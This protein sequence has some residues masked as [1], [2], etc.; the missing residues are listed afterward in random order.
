[1]NLRNKQIINQ[2][3]SLANPWLK[4]PQERIDCFKREAIQLI[5][6]PE[7]FTMS[8]DAILLA[9]FI[10]LPQK[11]HFRYMD[12]CSGHG[13][14]P[15]LLSARTDE[16]L[17][18]VE[19]QPALVD[20]AR[21]SIGL[22]GLDQQIKMIESDLLELPLAD[23][24]GMD[25]I[26]CNPPFFVVDHSNAIHHLD[27]HALARHEIALTL[28][29]WVRQASRMLKTKGKLFFVHRPDRLDDIIEVLLRY[30]FSLNRLKFIYPKQGQL[31]NMIL[32]EA[33]YYGGRQGVKV[34]PPL[35]VHQADN[36][37]TPEMMA[38]YYD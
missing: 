6:S 10:Q 37:Y 26:S 1:M 25:V 20:M 12:F 29:Q 27:S 30:H 35:V 21:R 11:R 14:I 22:N 36:S 4:S 18:G 16:P 5:Q 7:Y 19:I 31:A 9:D 15:L 33:I 34:E 2:T 23:W 32:V 38:I 3:E 28:D 13:V 8:L 17:V 24:Q